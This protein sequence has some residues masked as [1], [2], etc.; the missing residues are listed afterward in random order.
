[1]LIQTT[2]YNLMA[3]NAFNKCLPIIAYYCFFIIILR[4]VEIIPGTFLDPASLQGNGD[5]SSF[6][7]QQ[8]WGMGR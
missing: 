2:V 7:Q 8:C 3:N 5:F 4:I 1:M 6:A